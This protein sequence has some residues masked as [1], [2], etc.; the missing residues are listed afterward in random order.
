MNITHTIFRSIRLFAEQVIKSYL[1]ALNFLLKPAPQGADTKIP[2]TP[3]HVYKQGLSTQ[4][5]AVNDLLKV[6]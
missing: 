3:S 1:M 6:Q 2:N 5:Q 4:S